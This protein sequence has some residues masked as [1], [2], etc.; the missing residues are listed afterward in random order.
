MGRDGLP[1]DRGV[2]G[3]A[4]AVGVVVTD[5]RQRVPTGWWGGEW[6]EAVQHRLI[7]VWRTALTRSRP[8]DRTSGVSAELPA[9]QVCRCLMAK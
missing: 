6:I 1:S 9:G 2:G 3:T 4:G 7:F 8:E 5:A